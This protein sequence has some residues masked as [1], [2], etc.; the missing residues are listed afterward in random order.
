MSSLPGFL[1]WLPEADSQKCGPDSAWFWIFFEKGLLFHCC[2]D[3]S[4]FLSAENSLSGYEGGSVVLCHFRQS[5]KRGGSE[6]RMRLRAQKTD[7]CHSGRSG[8]R[9]GPRRAAF[10]LLWRMP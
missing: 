7:L 2:Y 1:I 10:Q 4:S 8:K 6:I 9:R 3:K 5:G